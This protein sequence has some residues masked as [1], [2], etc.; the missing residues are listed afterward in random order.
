[1]DQTTSTL[2][3]LALAEDIGSGDVT[4]EYFVPE[5]RLASG[6]IIAK[7]IGF[8]AGVEIAAEVFRRVDP[9]TTVEILLESG[10]PV[11]HRTQ[12]L[13]VSGKAR[14][15][16][17]AER[18]A[19][20]F[21]QR[22]SGV[23]TKTNHFVKLTEGTKARILDTRKT[24][25]GWRSLEKGAVLAGGGTNH[26]IGLYDRAMVKDNHLMAEGGIPA[27]QDAISRL[28]KEKPG[29]AVELEADRLDQVEAFLGLEGVDY[30]LLDNMS[31]D[32]LRAAVAL[33]KGDTPQL[34]ASGGVNLE[35]VAGIAATGVDFISV[36]AVTH[37]AVALDL[38]LEFLSDES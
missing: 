1:M 17:A 24:T 33:R 19:L 15:L 34:E 5:D 35:T 30:I 23:A 37:S 28:R 7:D 4:S 18:V 20:N 9:D 27:M 22:L 32:E 16:L 29:V 13:K 14:S 8:V 3:D 26:R 31:L 2:I 38:S 21:L 12:V 10:N 11:T 36:G 6:V 25:P